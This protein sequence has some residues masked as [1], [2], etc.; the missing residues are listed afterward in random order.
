M[1]TVSSAKGVRTRYINTLDK[2][3]IVAKDLLKQDVSRIELSDMV[4]Q[5]QKSKCLLKTYSEKLM[6]QVDKLSY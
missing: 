4:K 2:E 6:H 1:A 3:L 5:I